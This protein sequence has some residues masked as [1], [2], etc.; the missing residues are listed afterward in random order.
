MPTT[1]LAIPDERIVRRIH[2]I[3]GR[4]VMLDRDLA[5]LYD[6]ETKVL[7]QA[8]RRNRE[9][10][11]NEFMFQLTAGEFEGLRSQIVTSKSR[12]G[13]RYEP[14]AFTEQ[15]VAMLSA[16][17]RSKKAVAISILIIKAFVRMRELLETN[18]VLRAKLAAIEQQLGSHSKQIREVY[19]LLRRL[20]DEPVNPKNQIGF[21]S[22]KGR[23]GK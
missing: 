13:R 18:E 16:V 8:V 22:P 17:L 20:I 2:V 1:S 7:N 9:R 19:S 3:R 21:Q 5:E 11:P 14:Y 10:F 15:G 23:N 6:V 4:K 12:G